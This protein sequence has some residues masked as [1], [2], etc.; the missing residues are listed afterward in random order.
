MVGSHMK[1]SELTAKH[2]ASCSKPPLDANE[3]GGHSH[4]GSCVCTAT[5]S[6]YRM[7][8]MSYICGGF[9]GGLEEDRV[10]FRHP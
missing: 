5:F 2:L 1:S 6:L 3:G 8:Q 9:G 7:W 4:P 10:K